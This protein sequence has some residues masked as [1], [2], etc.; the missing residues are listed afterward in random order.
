MA[1][2]QAI[3]ADIL[4]DHNCRFRSVSQQLVQPLEAN[5][6]ASLGR[7]IYRAGDGIANG[8]WQFWKDAA[9]IVAHIPV[10]ARAYLEPFDGV[11]NC[12]TINA[13]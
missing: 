1:G 13:A 8:G 10:N 6:L 9:D 4:H 7:A 3:R 12:R 5:T 2:V 11:G